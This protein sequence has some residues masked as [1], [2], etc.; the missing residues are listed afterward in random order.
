[1]ERDEDNVRRICQ[2]IEELEPTNTEVYMILKS[3]NN[4]R[5]EMMRRNRAT[6]EAGDPGPSGKLHGR[7]APGVS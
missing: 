2:L 4:K 3:L 7:R 5:L 6:A 1:M